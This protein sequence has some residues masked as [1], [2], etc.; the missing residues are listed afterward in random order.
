MAKC[1]MASVIRITQIR[2]L[3]KRPKDQK[4]AIK[5]L[6][7]GRMHK[8]VVLLAIPQVLGMVNKVNHLLKVEYIDV[9]R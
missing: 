6:G 1:M 2:S 7:L 5:A 8:S 3:I 4:D 9:C